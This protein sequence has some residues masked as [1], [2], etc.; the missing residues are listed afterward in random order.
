MSTMPGSDGLRRAF[1]N[2]PAIDA[3]V[4]SKAQA[5]TGHGKAVALVIVVVLLEVGQL[6]RAIAVV[7]RRPVGAADVGGEARG[8]GIA[9]E[10][11]GFDFEVS[12]D[13][14]N[15]PV[16]VRVVEFHNQ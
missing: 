6:D 10:E 7:R 9:A 15:N 3:A 16:F 11:Q 12:S 5:F 2:V 14:L 13:H 8:Q 1:W 4:R